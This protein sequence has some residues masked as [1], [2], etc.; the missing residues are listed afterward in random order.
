MNKPTAI[1]TRDALYAAICA[2][3]AVIALAVAAGRVV[4]RFVYPAPQITE[5]MSGAGAE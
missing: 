5:G 1:P 4:R 2:D 3:S